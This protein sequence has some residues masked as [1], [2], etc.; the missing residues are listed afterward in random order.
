MTSN[1]LQNKYFLFTCESGVLN[2]REHS[3]GPRKRG[4]NPSQTNRLGQ[5][6]STGLHGPVRIETGPTSSDSWAARAAPAFTG[7]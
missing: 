3:D 1:S 4:H 6:R 2:V 7:R 5:Y